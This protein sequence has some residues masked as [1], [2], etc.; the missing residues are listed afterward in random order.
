M[1]WSRICITSFLLLYNIC[2]TIMHSWFN[3]FVFNWLRNKIYLIT[4]EYLATK[5]YILTFL[6]CRMD[7][8]S[9]L[10]RSISFNYLNWFFDKAI[11]VIMVLDARHLIAIQHSITDRWKVV[12]NAFFK[13]F[14][15]CQA[16][17][18]WRYL[19]LSILILF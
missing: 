6:G 11:T 15:Y 18:S 7:I 19:Y 10:S 3:Y 17:L 1:V 12:C 13:T 2:I 4:W 8:Y 9:F 5:P 16:K 14:T